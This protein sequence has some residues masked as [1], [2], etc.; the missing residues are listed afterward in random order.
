MGTMSRRSEGNRVALQVIR[1]FGKLDILVNNAAEQRVGQGL[2]QISTQQ[3]EKTFRTNL[4]GYSYL[5]KAALPIRKPAR[6]PSAPHHCPAWR[7][8]NVLNLSSGA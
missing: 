1:K 3:L 6:P 8:L 2:G 4:F 5:L 7:D